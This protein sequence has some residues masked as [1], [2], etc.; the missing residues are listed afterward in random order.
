MKSVKIIRS[1]LSDGSFVYDLRITNCGH[2]VE[3]SLPSLDATEA[4][5]AVAEVVT[6]LTRALGDSVAWDD[7]ED[8]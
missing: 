4:T 8:R 2:H 5:I 3:F 6:A 1:K 7:M